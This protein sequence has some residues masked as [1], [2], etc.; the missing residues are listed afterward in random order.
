MAERHLAPYAVLLGFALGGFFDGIMLHQVL[1]W[2]HLLSLV[3]GAGDLRAQILWDGL[4]HILMYVLAA[5]G[6]AGLWRKGRDGLDRRQLAVLLLLGFGLWQ[7]VD[8]VLFHWIMG[9]HRIRVDRPDPLLW[10]LGWLVA[11]GGPPLLA[12]WLLGRGH[13]AASLRKA[14]PLLLALTIGAAGAGWLALQGPPDQR[15]TTVVFEAGATEPEMMAALVA[16]GATVAGGAP[17]QGIWVVAID[18]RRSWELYRRGAIFVAG[19]GLPAGCS[20][21]TVS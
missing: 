8:V 4:F 5:I 21:W 3:P 15:F 16:S 20:A 14:P 12:A 18:D 2:H 11:I 19:V 6:L 10:D 1:Q 13:R 9:I 17:S 7:V